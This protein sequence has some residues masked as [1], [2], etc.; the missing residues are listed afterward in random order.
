[1]R[2]FEKY[3]G[4]IFGDG[5]Y[6][7]YLRVWLSTRYAYQVIPTMYNVEKLDSHLEA[8]H[9]GSLFCLANDRY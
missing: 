6:F 3:L 9:K 5:H 8:P 4:N 1:M 2:R 7:F